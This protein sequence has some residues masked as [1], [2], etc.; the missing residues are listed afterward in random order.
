MDEDDA[1]SRCNRKA[2]QRY[3]S[4]GLRKRAVCDALAPATVSG[5]P[6]TRISPPPLP[7]SAEVD[8]PVR[9]FNDVRVVFDH[10][11]GVALIAQSDAERQAVAE[12][13]QSVGRWSARR[14][15]TA[16]ARYRA[17]TVRAPVTRWASPPESD[18]VA[19]DQDGYRS[20]PRP[21]SVCSLRAAPEPHQELTRFFNGHIQH[22]VDG[23]AFVLN[24]SSVSGYSAC[25]CTGR[26]ARN[27]RRKC[28]STLMTP[29][30][31]TLRSDRA[32]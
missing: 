7:P 28:I 5:V 16:P 3:L 29:S 2:A 27:I 21:S 10:H 22:F 19:D 4:I 6:E 17:S 13:R 15:Y 30:P 14:E 1:A 9:R 23:L 20:V 31:G 25:L 11:D 24:L 32:R 12:Y 26:T 18:V 8:N